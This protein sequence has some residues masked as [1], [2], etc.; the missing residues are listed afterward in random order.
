MAALYLAFTISMD[1]NRV[2]MATY[3][4]FDKWQRNILLKAKT[5]LTDISKIA[6]M[7]FMQPWG[8]IVLVICQIAKDAL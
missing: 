3:Y 6:E 1:P 4:I 2:P 5:Y 7:I 8:S